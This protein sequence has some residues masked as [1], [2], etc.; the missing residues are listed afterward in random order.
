[1]VDN[2]FPYE[3]WD[4]HQVADHLMITPKRHVEG[5]AEFDAAERQEVIELLAKYEAQG[6]SIYARAPLNKQKTV[7]HQHTHLIK[8]HGRPKRFQ[9]ACKKPYVLWTV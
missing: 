3:I 6:Y 7:P 5:M 9:V 8:L 2:L 4:G 1:M